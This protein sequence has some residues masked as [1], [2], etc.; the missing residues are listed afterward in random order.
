MLAK[1]VHNVYTTTPLTFTECEVD[2][3]PLSTSDVQRFWQKVKRGRPG[4]C[5]LW[6]ASRIGGREGHRYGQ[7]AVMTAGGKTRTRKH[8]YAHRVAWILTHGPIPPGQMAL[9]QCDQAACCN[10]RHLFLGDQTDNMRDA[11]AKGRLNV[12]RKR[13][14]GFKSELITRYLAGEKTQRELAAEYGVSHIT[15]CRWLKGLKQPYART[16]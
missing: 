7:F 11:S 9:H 12:P 15:V 13:T 6:Q 14:R 8:L 3:A 16:A 10:P 1:G 5:W 4:E 2:G